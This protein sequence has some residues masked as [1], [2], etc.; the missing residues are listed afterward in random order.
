LDIA[1]ADVAAQLRK[2]G[3]VVDMP[4]VAALED[5]P[6]DP[7][8]TSALNRLHVPSSMRPPPLLARLLRSR[9]RSL[10]RLPEFLRGYFG[11]LIER[12]T[13]RKFNENL[14]TLER[15]LKASARPD[16]V[17]LFSG[18]ATPGVCALALASNP[19]TVLVSLPELAYELKLSQAWSLMRRICAWR[20]QEKVHPFLYRPVQPNQIRCAVFA[21][22]A[23]RDDAVKY[24]L[25]AGCV[26][27]IYFGVPLSPMMARPAPRGRLLWIGRMNEGKGLHQ[28]IDAMPT[29]RLAVPHATLTVIARREN[30]AYQVS[31]AEAISRQQLGDAVRILASVERAE[32]K[33]AYAEHDVLLCLSPFSEPVPLVMMEAFAAGL[34]VIISTPRVPSPL[35][36]PEHTCLCFDPDK[37]HTLARAVERLQR[38]GELRARLIANARK[39]IEDS[40]SLDH[41]G[42]QY[43]ALLR[44]VTSESNPGPIAGR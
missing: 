4:L 42:A 8:S 23:W 20:L 2:R 6:G 31:I 35:V 43:D 7:A 39:L 28:F 26:H 9:L 27:T 37:P 38:D 25:G 10:I 30:E 1:V 17:L 24:G 14:F 34:P 33:N 40:F 15:V 13:M 18:Y 3:W 16:A 19:R 22:R 11:L 12:A 21:S 36:L 32:L 44:T 5:S 41:M 29:I